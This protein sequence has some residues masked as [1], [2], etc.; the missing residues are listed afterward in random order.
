MTKSQ[1]NIV[2]IGINDRF[3][4]EF[5]KELVA[6]G[7]SVRTIVS[8]SEMYDLVK[9]TFRDSPVY[10]DI[11]FLTPKFIS[12]LKFD[13]YALSESL[14]HE[15]SKLENLFLDISDRFCYFPLSVRERKNIY[16]KNLLFWFLFFKE[17][18]INC[19][20]FNNSPHFGYDNVVYTMAKR[21][22]VKTLYTERTFIKNRVLLKSDYERYYR[23]P[24][25]YKKNCTINEL[26]K[27]MDQNI[28]KGIFAESSWLKAS[29]EINKD[30]LSDLG[31][32]EKFN[33]NNYG[34]CIL[35]KAERMKSIL[36]N[37]KI[38]VLF[39]R[40]FKRECPSAMY[41]NGD[42][43]NAL[44]IF[45]LN[46]ND[47][48]NVR[49]MFRYY[50]N[51]VSQVDYNKKY[52]F[53]A[54]HFQ[55]ERTTLPLGGA[56]HEQFNAINILSKSIPTDWVIYVKE[57]PRQFT[58]RRLILKHKHFR[59][60]SDYRKILSLKNVALISEYE[61]VDRLIKHAQFS[62]TISGTVG[63]QSLLQKKPC[64]LFGNPWYSPCESCFVVKSIDE[65][66]RCIRLIEDKTAEDVQ[67]DLYRFISFYQKDFIVSSNS[68]DY[69]VA[70]DLKYEDLVNNLADKFI[71]LIEKG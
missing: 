8:S 30:V 25:N 28:Y 14:I 24:E 38:F 41:M 11:D 22:E 39:K 69:A 45:L 71:Q 34:A 9:D 43:F 29:Q 54:M 40:L 66:G 7:A 65:C 53:F 61:D 64:V 44:R 59:N 35:L 13:K 18:Y 12:R 37:K 67:K 68:Y 70:S 62:A 47:K 6:R 32:R 15:H 3:F 2:V 51:N 56:F 63:W 42:S 5:A 58:Q 21:F 52:V 1:L 55:P 31:K 57:H 23:I 36:V 46:W 26:I 50:S 49:K 19:V 20:F 10:R 48:K 60:T 27:S 17:N 16:V 4:L 33:T